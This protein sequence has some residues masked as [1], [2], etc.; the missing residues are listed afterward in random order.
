MMKDWKPE[1]DEKLLSAVRGY[2]EKHGMALSGD[3]E[4]VPGIDY[5]S[6]EIGE[7]AILHVNLPPMSNYDVEE[8]EHTEAY[9]NNKRVGF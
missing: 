4:Y 6:I 3:I 5:V 7:I 2:F 8:T 1:N 9:F